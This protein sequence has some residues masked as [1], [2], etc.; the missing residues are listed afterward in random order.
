MSTSEGNVG[1][2]LVASFVV[3]FFC[4]AAAVGQPLPRHW[5]EREVAGGIIAL[6]G[7]QTPEPVAQALVASGIPTGIIIATGGF[8]P[9]TSRPLSP[10]DLETTVNLG[11][12]QGE[13]TRRHADLRWREAG[14]TLVIEPREPG[15]CHRALAARLGVFNAD[16]EAIPVVQRAVRRIRR[17]P[18]NGVPPGFV[19]GGLGG[20]SAWAES[21]RAI[22]LY[23]TPVAVR[24]PD[25]SVEELLT[26]IILQVP[27]LGWAVRETLWEPARGG[28][29][30]KR[31]R[32]I[33]ELFTA[34]SWLA[35]SY[36]LLDVKGEVR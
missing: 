22:E 6:I 24:L 7:E 2:A 31:H 1:G 25:P 3:S 28:G 12:V 10:A 5:A 19:G 33:V 15:P 9:P 13:F 34:G 27:G 21:E 35:T 20:E 30:V 11:A 23:R 32:C 14:G 16:G 29:T 17:E 4:A 36:D 26:E 18:E 8:R